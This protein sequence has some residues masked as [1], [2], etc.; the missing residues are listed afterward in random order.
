[1]ANFN[2]YNKALE[3]YVVILYKISRMWTVCSISRSIQKHQS[4]EYKYYTRLGG[5]G[6]QSLLGSFDMDGRMIR[7]CSYGQIPSYIHRRPRCAA[8]NLWQ[9][10]ET[11][12]HVL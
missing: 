12:E 4:V 11:H 8:T 5:S 6:L 10:L 7:T 3:C 1:M 9:C 2:A